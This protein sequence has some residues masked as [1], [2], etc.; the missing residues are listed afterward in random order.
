[1][2]SFF[3]CWCNKYIDMSSPGWAQNIGKKML[4][5]VSINGNIVYDQDKYTVGDVPDCSEIKCKHPN[6]CLKCCAQKIGAYSGLV[7]DVARIVA[8]YCQDEKITLY[9]FARCYD[10]QLIENGLAGLAYSA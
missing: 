8:E 7:D 2:F 3:Y 10:R 4:K 5:K 6:Y 1:M 9:C